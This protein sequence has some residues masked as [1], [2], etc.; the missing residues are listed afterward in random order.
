LNAI[1][2]FVSSDVIQTFSAFLEFCYVA[3]RNV[4]T[5]SSLK[6]LKVA[7]QQ[8]HKYRTVFSGTV[9]REGL[10]GFSLPRQ[11]S[12]VHYYN[13]IKNFGAPNSLCSSITESKHIVAVKRPWRRSNRYRALSQILKV[14]E[15]LDKLAAARADF[16]ARGMLTNSPLVVAGLNDSPQGGPSGCVDDSDDLANINDNSANIDIDLT[17]IDNDPTNVDDG[18]GNDPNVGDEDE[19]DDELSDNDAG[20]VESE[21]LMNEVRLAQEKG[22]CHLPL[23][24]HKLLK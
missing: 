4:I 13:N 9:R 7:L 3:R 12:L 24:H 23:P 6:D 16:T 17:N 2:G 11:H 18:H 19:E 1:E 15:R 21:P 8:F 14:N 20:P 5:E 22:K 10:A